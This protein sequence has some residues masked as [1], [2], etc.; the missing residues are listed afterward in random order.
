MPL[1]I[2]QL[3]IQRQQIP[4]VRGR[5]RLP[6]LPQL[7]NFAAA[8]SQGAAVGQQQHTRQLQNFQAG[9][10]IVRDQQARQQ[11]QV[12][13]QQKRDD[14]E[15]TRS[16]Q[17]GERDYRRQ[18]DTMDREVT[19]QADL[20]TRETDM[21]KS[22]AG[23]YGQ[24][25]GKS[26]EEK[27]RVMSQWLDSQRSNPKFADLIDDEDYEAL[28][29]QWDALTAHFD[30]LNTPSRGARAPIS[31]N[32]KTYVDP[33]TGEVFK[34]SMIDGILSDATT[35]QPLGRPLTGLV[36]Q[37]T[38]EAGVKTEKK[39]QAKTR[40]K[41]AAGYTDAGKSAAAQLPKI[42]L[43]KQIGK[44]AQLGLEG[45][46]AL[47]FRKF[48]QALGFSVDEAKIASGEALEQLTVDSTLALTDMTSGSISDREMILFRSAVPSLT[49]SPD[50]F[51]L[52]AEILEA[53][54]NRSIDQA[55]FA[56]DLIRKNNG[57][58]PDDLSEQITAIF[59]PKLLI[60]YKKLD[61]LLGISVPSG[62]PA[63]SR[64]IGKAADGS[65][66]DVW[67]DP[68]EKQWVE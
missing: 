56:R 7:P 6:S 38:Y 8:E 13:Q 45:N 41:V 17:E 22:M 28:D 39:A 62:M 25:K 51:K 3:H 37:S 18:Q 36:T 14:F 31:K 11:Q 61:K 10:D 68:S 47:G 15:Y 60:P 48:G 66:R 24:L 42:R 26:P 55:Q 67:L 58:I 53:G 21:A 4:Q 40:V 27:K 9:A 57:S 33:A 34:T 19:A 54:A 44:D 35:G 30:S 1:D 65:G 5:G 63:G 52:M 16:V 32:A 46:I 59:R 43:M 2:Q 64:V 20:E 29:T 50:G 49:T 12:M 23:V